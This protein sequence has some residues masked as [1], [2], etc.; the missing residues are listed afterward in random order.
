VIAPKTR[1]A[2]SGDAGVAYQVVGDGPI[3]LVVRSGLRL[4]NRGEHSL[5]GVPDRWRLY[6]LER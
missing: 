4:A 2:H 1:H 6:A 3:D 5:R